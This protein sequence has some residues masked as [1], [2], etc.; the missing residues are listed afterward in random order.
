MEMT[1]IVDGLSEEYEGQVST[2][3]LDAAQETNAELQA[4]FGLRGH[5]SFVVLD[6]DGRVTQHFFGPQAEATLREAIES[7]LPLQQP[8]RS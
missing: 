3:K 1:P 5:P 4:E 2:Y 8:A 7:V 6:S